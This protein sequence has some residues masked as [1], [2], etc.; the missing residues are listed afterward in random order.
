MKTRTVLLILCSLFLSVAALA[1]TFEVDGQQSQ[2]ASNSPNNK[3]K[4]QPAGQANTNGDNGIGW[5]SSIEVGRLARA[6]QDALR[7]GNPGAAADYAERAVK[8]APQDNKLWFLLGYTSRLAGRY[9]TSVDAYQ[10]GLQMSPGNADGM[11]GLAQTY[12]R[13]GRNDD[14]KRLLSQVIRENPK[15]TNDLLILGELEMRTG[16]TQQGINLLQ[17]AEAQQPSAHAELMI[18]VAYLKLK[19]PEKAKQMLD[20]AKKHSPNN[21]EIF[22]AA[23]NYYREEHDYKAAITT[24]KSAPKMTPSILA[25]LGYT[26]ELDGDKEQAA[27]AYARAANEKPNEIGYQLSAAQ[28]ELRLGDTE[29][30]RQYLNRAAAIDANHYRLHAIKAL[31]AKE[32]NR[33][34]DAIAE[35][36]AAIAALPA[37][38]VPEGQLYPVQLRL[39]LAELYRESGDDEAAHQQLAMAEQEIS[40]LNVEGTAKAEFLR[41]RASIKTSD[42]DLKGAEADLL[43]ARKLD[44]DNDN[45]TLQYANLLWKEGRSEESRKIYEGVLAKDPE[46][47]YALEAMGYLYREENDPKMAAEYFNRLAKAYPDDYIPYLAL[48]DL[49]TQTRQFQLADDN[50][51]QA[52]KLAPENPLIIA[53]AANAAIEAQQIKLAGMWVNRAKGTMNDDPRVMRERERYLFHSGNYAESAKLGY[54]V[55]Q[56]LPKDRNA[57]VYLTYDLYNLGRYDDALA[58]ADKYDSIL[59][60]EPNFPL[61]EGHVHKHSELLD[62][63]VNDYGRAIQRDPK[64]AEAYV[65]RGYTLNDMQNAQQAAQDFNTALQLAPNNGIAHLGLAFSDLQLRHPKEAREQAEEAQKLLGESGST[66]LALATAY[67]QEHLLASAE[68]EYRAAIKFAP[69]DLGLQLALADTLYDM[70]RYQ[71]S[72]DALNAALGISPDDPLIY[73]RMAH[74][75]A[76]LGRKDETMRY[77]EAAEKLGGEQSSILLDTGD[78]L[79]TLGD[80]KAAMDRFARALDAP[81]ANRVDARL[82]IARLMVKYGEDEDAKQQISLAFAESRIGEAP[83]VTADNLI[84]AANLLLAMHDFT[85]AA[86]YFQR[87][88]QAGASPDIVAIGMANTDLAQG[89]TKQANEELATIKSDPSANQNYDYL[90][91]QGEVY[92]QRHENWNALAMLAQA[93][94]LGGSELAQLEGM[95]VA[96]EEGMRV[97]E[98]LSMLTDFTT[99]GLYDDYTVYVLDQQIFGLSS[100]SPSLPPPRSQQESLWTTAYRYHF[101]N[102][103]PMLSGFFQ[104]RNATGDESLP[105]E[106]LIIHRNTFDYNFNSALN[107]VIHLGDAWIALNTGL[108]FTLRR[109]SS[110]P[111]YENQNLFRQFVYANSSSFGNWLSFNASLYHEA[112]PFTATGYKL[113]SNDLGTTLQFTVGRPWGNTA[114]IT[115]YTRRDLTYS[116]LVR[117]FFT[118]STYAGL[119]RKFLDKKLT[120]SLLAEYIRA[121][122]VQDTL[123]ATAHVLRPVASVQY[124]M[125]PAWSVSGQFAYEGGSAFQEYN[126]SYSSFYISYVRPLHRSFSDDA[127]EYKIAYPLRFAVGIETEQ[128][129]DF[130]GTARSGTLIRPVVRLSIF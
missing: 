59:P 21:V 50:Y 3:K 130:T 89:K 13:M 37:G 88:G 62:E 32:E 82:A 10:R 105:Q 108:Q 29:K 20:L 127:G 40:K 75:Y 66:H 42:N 103:F 67:R 124:N 12:A 11:S 14:A 38:G 52:Y 99:A 46:N 92:R 97:T 43:E 61:I 17:R 122:R 9:Q 48:G 54:Q 25:D 113:D 68:Q 4:A 84:E 70:R 98:H 45:I 5:G 91:A 58:V 7:H 116:P 95:Q 19:Q 104:I 30:T 36:K 111:Q 6:A 16:D 15:R 114:L 27:Q 90:I 121:F 83:P 128:F 2:P 74:A 73:G 56:K 23:A 55:L 71:Q 76:H 47:R 106:A 93:D 125:N 28:A 110:A 34:A 100:K 102:S 101:D 1:Q 78:A 118:T 41:V 39:N 57:S 115:G 85:L 77:V 87:A 107:P 65:N 117:Q 112:G 69:N 53:N 64:M 44:P 86:D 96:S 18:A 120:A 80:R 31:L 60:N 35:Y 26:Y 22:Q 33:Q 129:P 63:A 94:Q 8:A 24:L 49:Y 72:I 109:D 81:D 51:Q 119:Q 126:N 123:W 79:L